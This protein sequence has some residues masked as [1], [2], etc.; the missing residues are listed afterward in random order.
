MA[1][2]IITRTEHIRGRRVLTRVIDKVRLLAEREP[3]ALVDVDGF[4]AAMLGQEDPLRR[5]I[6]RALLQTGAKTQAVAEA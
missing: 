6:L 1:T 3:E 5:G 4:L 2:E